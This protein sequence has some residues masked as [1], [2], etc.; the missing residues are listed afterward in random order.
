MDNF[1]GQ[2]FSHDFLLHSGYTLLVI[3]ESVSYLGLYLG[4]IAIIFSFSGN[5][6]PRKK[7]ARK[8][9]RFKLSHNWFSSS[10]A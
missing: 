2:F 8:G 9:A 1:H 10:V 3:S 5:V 7:R 6:L 4:K